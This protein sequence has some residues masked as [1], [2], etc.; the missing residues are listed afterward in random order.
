MSFTEFAKVAVSG[1]SR[2]FNKIL[3]AGVLANQST[4]LAKTKQNAFWFANVV[5]YSLIVPYVIY[6][7]FYCAAIGHSR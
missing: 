4:P 1:F 2:T 7:P 6:K 3:L 5:V